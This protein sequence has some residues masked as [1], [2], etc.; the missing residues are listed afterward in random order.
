MREVIVTLELDPVSVK[1]SVPK[2]YTDK[3]ILQL[4]K[5]RIH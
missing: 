3:E 2:N 4:A 1:L 5:K